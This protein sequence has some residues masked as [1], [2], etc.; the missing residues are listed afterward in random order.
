MVEYQ[1][2]SF[3]LTR[4]GHNRHQHLKHDSHKSISASRRSKM[5]RSLHIFFVT[6]ILILAADSWASPPR[7]TSYSDFDT[8]VAP[9]DG[10]ALKTLLQGTGTNY[11]YLQPGTYMLQNPVTINRTGSLYLHGIDRNGT[12]LVAANPAQPLFVV[13]AAPLI[14]IAGVA[15][16]PTTTTTLS[17]AIKFQNTQPVALEMFESMLLNST[18]EI[19][20]PGSYR[21][22]SISIYPAGLT[23]AGVL[24]NHEGADVF[25]WGGDA[26]GFAP[27]AGYSDAAVAWQKLGRLRVYAMT[28][29]A[30]SG[31]AAFRIESPSPPTLGPFHVIANVRS[32]TSKRLLNVPTTNAVV[33]VALKSDNGAWPSSDGSDCKLV[34]HVAYSAVVLR[35]DSRASRRRDSAAALPALDADEDARSD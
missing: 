28:T 7:P 1:T 30:T 29:E 31:L 18:I 5:R 14:N 17:R 6:F 3:L 35:R 23:D 19:D 4:L 12:L 24:V 32:E 13:T 27:G 9:R 8:S 16:F 25:I 11:I 10:A 26:S 33:N 2:L 21:L 34:T 15:L 20:G 22:Q